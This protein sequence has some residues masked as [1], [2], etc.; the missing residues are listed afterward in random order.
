M[1]HKT[2]E[3]I[4]Y[5]FGFCD[6][7]V[8]FEAANEALIP[9]V[10]RLNEACSALVN[11]IGQIRPGETLYDI[12]AGAGAGAILAAKSHGVEVVA[13]EPDG[14]KF[15]MLNRNIRLNGL[16]SLVRAY[17]LAI[18]DRSGV[19]DS[20]ASLMDR[21]GVI[22]ERL[23]SLDLSFFGAH[24]Q[25]IKITVGQY[26]HAVIE[27][28]KKTLQNPSLQSL[29]I[30]FDATTPGYRAVVDSLNHYGFFCFEQISKYQFEKVIGDEEKEDGFESGRSEKNNESN[31]V[32]TVAPEN[33]VFMRDVNRFELGGNALK[34]I[35]PVVSEM[36]RRAR[37]HV[38]E[39]IRCA[40][41]SRSPYGFCHID[42]LFPD[43]FYQALLRYKP[44]ITQMAPISE[45]KTTSSHYRNR[46]SLELEDDPLSQFEGA[47]RE[48][49]EELSGWLL[50]P[51]VLL[52]L[53]ELF[54]SAIRDQGIKNVVASARG[55]FT[56][57]LMGYSIAPHTDAV[58]R[59]I[60]GMIYIPDDSDHSHLGTSIYTPKEA[61]FECDGE[62][63][64][65]YDDYHSIKVAPYRPNSAFFF[66]K[67]R[68]SFHGVEPITEDYERDCIVYMIKKLRI[69]TD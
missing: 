29:L 67:S 69:E 50:G 46:F 48:F 2:I 31:I 61:G 51:E 24:P 66:L 54:K 16:Q 41:I 68:N 44:K 27:G 9:E 62:V 36:Q 10:E 32:V 65:H 25:H 33:H 43:D 53:I 1:S 63:H 19:G 55:L 38:V 18:S 11:W 7:R 28:M 40:E 23:D 64:H 57:D 39:R 14:Q 15:A 45:G 6:D 12:G 4:S 8:L 22:F 5:G 3:A 20:C 37:R 58:V 13:F 49:M 17:C 21:Q 42:N 26:S 47:Q 34:P 56:K 30:R 60:T 59:L 35:S 52:A